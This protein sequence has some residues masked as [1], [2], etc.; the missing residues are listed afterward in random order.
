MAAGPIAATPRELLTPAETAALLRISKASVYRLVER[1]E[2]PF[3]RLRGSLRFDR[4][5]IEAYLERCRVGPA[6]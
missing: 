5:D 6:A 2:V 3:Y 4:R 1:R